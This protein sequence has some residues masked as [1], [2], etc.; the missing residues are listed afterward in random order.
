[1]KSDK[2]KKMREKY[3]AT[4]KVHRHLYIAKDGAADELKYE[5]ISPQEAILHV[6]RSSIIDLFQFGYTLAYANKLFM[7]VHPSVDQKV[8]GRTMGFL[9]ENIW[10]LHIYARAKVRQG[11]NSFA[12]PRAALGRSML[13]SYTHF[14]SQSIPELFVNGIRIYLHGNLTEDTAQLNEE[15]EAFLSTFVSGKS[16][17]IDNDYSSGDEIPLKLDEEY[18]SEDELN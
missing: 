13:C 3:E 12:I 16:L 2:T 7:K 15:S 5:K 10:K 1:M 6:S 9:N 4:L 11:D 8:Y 18:Y 14:P 17:K